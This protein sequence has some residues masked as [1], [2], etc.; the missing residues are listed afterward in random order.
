MKDDSY[1]T[2]RIGDLGFHKF[3]KLEEVKEDSLP[4]FSLNS[5]TVSRFCNLVKYLHSRTFDF[6][7]S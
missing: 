4:R 6:I 5:K 2:N 1:N 3:T 7:N